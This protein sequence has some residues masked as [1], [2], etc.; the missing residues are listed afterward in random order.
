MPTLCRRDAGDNLFVAAAFQVMQ[1]DPDPDA[2][3]APRGRIQ[4][5][6]G[7]GQRRRE[8]F[9]GGDV[10]RDHGADADIARRRKCRLG[11]QAHVDHRGGARQQGLGI[12]R[13]RA[14]AGLLGAEAALLA[15]DDRDPLIQRDAFGASPGQA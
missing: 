11:L 3:V 15:L 1:P 7:V 12:G 10:R 5:G 6:G 2:I 4:Q 14:G 13:K 8:R 9:A